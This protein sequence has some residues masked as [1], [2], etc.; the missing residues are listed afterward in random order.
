MCHLC[1][2]QYLGCMKK[3]HFL[4]LPFFLLLLPLTLFA[5]VKLTEVAPT[6]T[7]QIT[8][9]DNER[10]DWIEIRNGGTQVVNLEGWSISNNNSKGWVLPETYIDPGARRLVFASGKNRGGNAVGGIDHWETALN[11]GDQWRYFIGSSPAP[12]NWNNI[13]FDASVWQLGPGGFGYG[14]GDDA[15]IVPNGTITVYYR[16]TFQVANPSQLLAAVLSIDYDDGFV[17]YLNGQEIARSSNISGTPTHTTLA[18]PEREASGLPPEAY[19]IDKATLANLL[20]PGANVLAVEIHNTAAGSSDLSG[21]TWLHF[22]LADAN[23]QYGPTPSWFNAGTPTGGELHTDFKLNFSEK[24]TLFNPAGE[25]VDSVSIGYLQPGHSR[26]RIN[27]DGGW[28]STATPT[29]GAT[30]GWDC[31]SGYAVA[32]G[33]ALPAGFYSGPQ[34]IALTGGGQIRYTTDGA[35]P[36]ASSTLYTNPIQVSATTVIRARRFDASLLPSAVATATYFINDPTTLTA[37]SVS[38]PPADFSEVYDNYSRK[39]AVAVEYF[40]KNKERHFVDDYAGYVVGNWSVGF[41]QKSLQFD[42]DEEFGSLGAMK[43]PIFAPDKPIESY[44]SFRIRNEDDDWTQARMRDRI[45]NELA[46]ETHAARAAYRNVAAFING[47][48]WGHYVARERLDNFFVR[49]NFGADPDSVNM[50]KTHYGLGNYVPEYGTIDDFFAMSDFIGNN[51]MSNPD[52]FKKAS[53]LLDIDNFTDYFETE[54]YVASTDW[55]QDY[56]NNLRL[57]KTRKNA[58]WKFLLWD[59]SYSAGNPLAGSTCAGC[60]VLSTTLSHDSRYGRMLRGLLGNPEYRRHFINRFADL[61]NTAFLPARA[62]ELINTNAAEMAPEMDRHDQ[63][64]GTGNLNSWSGSVQVLRD[65]YSQR[66]D[67]QREHIIDN[68]QLVKEVSIT[69]EANPPGAGTVKISTVVPK[70]LPWTGIYFH[71]NP[72]TVTAIA[73]P[74]YSFSHWTANPNIA[75]LNMATFTADVPAN[76]AFTANFTGTSSS[77][78]L[79]ISEINYHAHTTRDAGDWFELRNETDVPIEISDFYLRDQDWYHRFDVPTGTQIPGNG[80]LVFAENISKFKAE[81]PQ[82]VNVLAVPFSF[83]LSDKND[84]LHVYDRGGVEVAHAA[85][86]S[87]GNWPVLANGFGLTLERHANNSAP[88]EAGSWFA[89]CMGGTPGAYYSACPESSMLSEINYNSASNADAGDWIELHNATNTPLDLSGWQLRDELDDNVFVFPP[90]TVIGTA[91]PYHV[92]FQDAAK[93]SSLFPSVSNKTGPIGFG[94]NG[95]SDLIRLYDANGK[96]ALIMRYA[97]AAPWPVEADG[98]GYTL[99]KLEKNTLVH[100]AGNWTIGCLG[101]SPGKAYDP[102]CGNV[103]AD[104]LQEENASMQIWP[105]PAQTEFV[106][107]LS[108][109]NDTQVQLRDVFGKIVAQ[110]QTRNSAAVFQTGQLPR[111]LYFATATIGQKQL[112]T[113]LIL[114]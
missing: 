53:Q 44:R 77:T 21:R 68:F 78:A 87:D 94:F 104:D 32:P 98:A 92:F 17:A 86:R 103:G 60:D 45:V 16:R 111:G 105:N 14:D 79:K 91:Q 59:V 38:L 76:T 33:M 90:G 96:I 75:D 48:Y 2:K 30:N 27:D 50:V 70:T 81:H 20:L 69:L 74:G 11:E 113:K 43:Y 9:S 39:G 12:A 52:N 64:W 88:E 56:F 54:V 37:I 63:R 106:I 3:Q 101:G 65:F 26:M 18:V 46:A 40:D 58:P 47:E 42:V 73:N 28:C 19:P 108:G 7:N 80:N 36:T 107:K 34:S 95:A 41:A 13:G 97:D 35:I 112:S 8:D 109:Q 61:M 51:D 100:E 55:L 62:H 10:P 29:P 85:Y 24:I 89:G 67:K 99:E 25:I 72:V 1:A 22:G 57:F 23:I 110:Q 83:Q 31:F 4:R 6:N 84:A 114:N 71:G 49:D 5:Q 93:F 82:V 66:P 15:T 102:D